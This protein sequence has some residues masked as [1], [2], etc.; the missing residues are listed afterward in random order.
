M[1]NLGT[2][3]T[4]FSRSIKN[5][6]FEV[7]FGVKLNDIP[8]ILGETSNEVRLEGGVHRTDEGSKANLEEN[9]SKTRK[10]SDERSEGAQQSCE[11]IMLLLL[12]SPTITKETIE[13]EQAPNRQA[14][15]Q[16]A[17]NALKRAREVM[18]NKYEKTKKIKVAEYK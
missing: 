17:S 6:P 5:L 1:Q 15:R 11:E 14:M 8:K 10:Q 9:L 13:P 2:L 16:K 18:I 7:F 3:N 12:I 4:S